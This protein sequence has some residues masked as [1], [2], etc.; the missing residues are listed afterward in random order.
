[1]TALLYLTQ[2]T[3]HAHEQV[4]DTPSML[5][6]WGTGLYGFLYRYFEAANIEPGDL[7]CVHDGSR[8]IWG[9]QLHRLKYELDQAHIDASARAETWPT[10]VGWTGPLSPTYEDWRTVTRDEVLLTIAKLQE[11]IAISETTGLLLVSCY[12]EVCPQKLKQ[13][14]T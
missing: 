12:Q 9:Y 4:P 2:P 5:F 6:E 3:D 10:L 13:P 8:E 1:M 11:L 7:I 14:G